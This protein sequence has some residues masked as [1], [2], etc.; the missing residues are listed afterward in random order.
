M[1]NQVLREHV[2][3]DV[4]KRNIRTHWVAVLVGCPVFGWLT[5]HTGTVFCKGITHVDVDRRAIALQLP[6]ARHGNFV[7]MAY[8]VVLFVEIDGTLLAWMAV[9]VWHDRGAC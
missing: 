3:R 4:D 6:V 7:P 5:G 2:L 8:V 1:K 9:E